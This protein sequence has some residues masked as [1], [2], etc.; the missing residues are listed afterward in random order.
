MRKLLLLLLTFTTLSQ[1]STIA[2]VIEKVFGLTDAYVW[3]KKRLVLPYPGNPTRALF[4]FVLSGNPSLAQAVL[5]D[6]VYY[7]HLHRGCY[8]GSED[9]KRWLK[10]HIGNCNSLIIFFDGKPLPHSQN[11]KVVTSSTLRRPIE[12]NLTLYLIPALAVITDSVLPEIGYSFNASQGITP[13]FSKS[14]SVSGSRSD[15]LSS[16]DPSAG[17]ASS[18]VSYSS[19][20][21]FPSLNVEEFTVRVDT[22]ID[23][24]KLKAFL[25]Q[26][27]LYI[28]ED[29]YIT[30]KS[31]LFTFILHVNNIKQFEHPLN[32]PK[33]QAKS[34]GAGVEISQ[35]ELLKWFAL[36]RR[37]SQGFNIEA[38]SIYEMLK[39][40]SIERYEYRIDVRNLPDPRLKEAYAASCHAELM[41]KKAHGL[42]HSLD[43][44]ECT[45]G[46][47][48]I[49][50][51]LA[52]IPNPVVVIQLQG[53]KDIFTIDDVKALVETLKKDPVFV[54]KMSRDILDRRV[55]FKFF[56]F[57][58]TYTSQ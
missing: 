21:S 44:L 41:L 39:F 5:Y 55:P 57:T 43:S 4:G 36:Y 48:L 46:S 27:D 40:V 49:I 53:L 56:T 11:I 9:S 17:S 37:L 38:A 23:V 31:G 33:V 42:P 58:K 14:Y 28:K 50:S 3:E 22:Y 24:N 25:K 26:E 10:L 47:Q 16:K 7:R 34:T 1:A 19:S 8:Q 18:S 29:L 35:D 15:P 6:Y 12:E 54:E 20:I 13:S 30:P 2:E 32:I 52:E 45:K 51:T